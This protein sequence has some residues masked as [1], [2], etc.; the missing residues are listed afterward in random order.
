[1]T[2]ELTL[3]K[4]KGQLWKTGV[5]S[6]KLH[7]AQVAMYDAV[8]SSTSS[9][10]VINCSR[11]IGKS[12]FLCTYAIEQALRNPGIKI[13]YLAPQAKMV[14]KIIIP[15]IRAILKD[16]P[17]ELKPDYRVNEQVYTFKHNGSEIHIAGTDAE[18]SENLRGQVFHLVVCDE[19]GFMDDLEYVVASILM[20]MISTT[21]GRIILSST[22]PISPDHAFVQYVR[23]A[24]A[25]GYYIKKTILDN[26]LIDKN[27]IEELKRHSGGEN[28]DAWRRE[29]LA[30]F[31]TSE[32]DAIFPEAT[33]AQMEKLVKAVPRPLFYDSYV[34]ADLG[35]TDNTGILYAYWDFL[36]A[37]VI[38]EDE[39]LF[40]RPNS[41]KIAE[42]IKAKEKELWE[43]NNTTKEPYKRIVDGNDIT[44]SDLNSPP[45]NLRFVKTRNDDLQAAVNEA[46]VMIQNEQ[47]LINPKCKQLISQ[48]K[49]GIW[50]TTKKKFARSEGKGHFDLIAALIYL[51]RNIARHKN[52]YP[53]N[54]G[55]EL[56]TMY[57]DPRRQ[58]GPSQAVKELQKVLIGQAK[59]IFNPDDN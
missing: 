10:F 27:Q 17:S 25:G 48:V 44:I 15:R 30:E 6:W 41:S 20:P 53:H 54:L 35:Y 57:I 29:Y 36:Q 28:S 37:K 39:S 40:N 55:L 19:A 8:N 9:I 1:M 43:I 23:Q 21:K 47:I 2:E 31:V 52:P 14:K 3:S 13:C 7:D 45:H 24:E 42:V 11:Q 18:R 22:P 56:G 59:K 16:C 46:R 33:E 12:Y 32:E 5:L 26:P 34:S 4:A 58:A 49:Y 38:I 51:I 50:D